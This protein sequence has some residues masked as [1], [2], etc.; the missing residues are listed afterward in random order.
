[1]SSPQNL[2]ARSQTTIISLNR[3]EAKKNIALAIRAFAKV[4]PNAPRY[5]SK[6]RLVVAGASQ[7]NLPQLIFRR[8]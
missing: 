3:F 6:L 8:I 7:M 2:T 1:M 5:R 4:I